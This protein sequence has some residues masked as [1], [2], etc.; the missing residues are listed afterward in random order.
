MTPFTGDSVVLKMFFDGPNDVWK[1]LSGPIESI[2]ILEKKDL[3]HTKDGKSKNMWKLQIKTARM[4]N[5]I[6]TNPP[7]FPACTAVFELTMD[8]DFLELKRM[9][10]KKVNVKCEEAAR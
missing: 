9:D 6:K 7:D 2:E 1:S 3:D 8:W 10:I 4:E 5:S